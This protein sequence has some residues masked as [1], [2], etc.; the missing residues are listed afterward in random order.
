MN[1]VSHVEVV[2]VCVTHQDRP[3]RYSPGIQQVNHDRP[4]GRSFPLVQSS[5]VDGY[6]NLWHS[7]ESSSTRF[8]MTTIRCLPISPPVFSGALP[9]G[10][11]ET[12]KNRW[13]KR[14]IYAQP[15]Q[16]ESL[17]HFKERQK[18]CRFF[19]VCVTLPAGIFLHLS[20][21][22]SVPHAQSH[23]FPAVSVSSACQSRCG[24]P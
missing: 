19:W 18:T 8:P 7:S 15:R 20:S 17:N 6:G 2:I 3:V 23:T 22:N 21:L 14:L 11:T 1:I 12:R 9:R 16:I 13:K 4:P 5:S 24:P 10:L